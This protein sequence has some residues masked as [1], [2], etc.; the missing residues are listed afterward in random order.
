MT[1]TE[2]DMVA[3]RIAAQTR[4]LLVRHAAALVDG[5]KN[6]GDDPFP[7]SV[8]V[9]LSPVSA[10]TLRIK[11]TISFTT[12]KIKDEAEEWINPAQMTIIPAAQDEQDEH[13]EIDEHTGE[14]VTVAADGTAKRSR[15]NGSAR[16]EAGN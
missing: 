14:I 8:R 15:R 6:F 5:Y 2:M 4:D 1:L 7:I 3:A 11:S 9:V 13:E 16:V 12:E 10:G